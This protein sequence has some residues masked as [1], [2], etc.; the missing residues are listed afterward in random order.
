MKAAIWATVALAV[1]GAVMSAHGDEPPVA[2]DALPRI[3]S[4]EPDKAP[5]TMRLHDGLKLELVAS[6]P[7]VSSPVGMCFDEDG[8]LFVVEM[9]GYPDLREERPGRIK[10]LESTHHDGRYDKA[11]IYADNL[12]WPTS[13]LAYDG[14][15]FV[16][17]SPDLIYLKDTKHDGVADVRY[18]VF[19]GFGVTTVPLNVQGLVNGL[20]WGPDDRIW[21]TTSENGGSV[22]RPDSKD[23][24]LDLRR[25]DFSFDPRKLDLR[26]ENG[27]G[28]HGLSFDNFGR[29]YVCFNNKALQTF[30]YDAEYSGQNP[31]F[32]MPPALVDIFADGMDVYRI[33]PEEAWRVLRTQWRVAGAVSGPVEGGGRASGYFTS[34]SGVTIY[35]GDALPAQ[36][37]GNAFIAEPANN[38][39]HREVISPDGV[40]VIGHRAPEERHSEFLASTD[41]WFRP[42]QLANGPD[43]ALYV[44]DMYRET[45]EHPWSLPDSIKGRLDLHSGTERGRIWR[46]VPQGF[47]P[48]AMP[49]LSKA[50][51][52]ELVKLL[53]SLNGWHRDTAARLLYE[54]N[55]AS[56]IPLLK[57]LVRLPPSPAARYCALRSL[58]TLTENR[59]MDARILVEAMS[60]PEP[61]VR[62]LAV[63]LSEPLLRYDGIDGDL[64]QRLQGMANDP[65]IGVRYQLAFTIARLLNPSDA[66]GTLTK[67]AEHDPGDKWIQAAV[68]SSSAKQEIYLLLRLVARQD[69]RDS[70]AGKQFLFELAMLVGMRG[71]KRDLDL[72]IAQFGQQS[73]LSDAFTF[74]LARAF[75]E[76][77]AR[78][79]ARSQT[80][81]MLKDIVSRAMQQAADPA[82][83]TPTRVEAVRLLGTST[84]TEA[85]PVLL[86]LL[87]AIQPQAI[88]SAAISSLDRFADPQ[89]GQELVKRF[90]SFSPRLRSEALGV[91]AKRPDRA[92]EL[93]HAIESKTI[94]ASELPSPTATALRRSADPH[95][96][97]L[98]ARVL[99][100][101]AAGSRDAVVAAYMPALQLAGNADRGRTIYQQRC[102]SC[103]RLEGQG[104][105]VG[106]DLV[107]V[108]SAGKEKT[109]TNILDPNREIAPNYIAYIAETTN[110]ES[111][112]GVIA[113]ETGNSITLRQ[114]FG[115][116][117]TILRS[118]LKRLVSQRISLMPE[119]LEEGLKPQDFADLLEF[120]MTAK[121]PAT[122][123]TR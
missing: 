51:T 36:F 66:V 96:R 73:W 16:T 27:G 115:K 77:L 74:S 122:S 42:V 108:R 69:V 2:R 88:Q 67:I 82:I 56:A 3:A 111:L 48:P 34:C 86:P 46:I 107:T 103:H 117:T 84:Y 9:L 40:G 28:Q 106:P 14:G 24:P 80:Q 30:M 97:E 89:V 79:P 102:I 32:A 18:K 72:L 15:I 13:V 76:G 8:R 39:V 98:A 100:A 59:R 75:R 47:T 71:E 92:M 44:I 38:L 22:K 58:F 99:S 70:A 6:E 118:D 35:S 23:P 119:G 20:T 91:L 41:T 62:A 61:R 85:S 49:T 81:E 112:V 114:A 64:L 21:G 116:D 113:S 101:P 123:P 10:L 63:K 94:R 4:T 19:T 12:P 68:I 25:R 29:R 54:R 105:A 93:L 57:E 31:L 43:G 5:L 45:I 26:A 110:G 65:D 37:Q 109:L 7:L 33:S 17:A 52:P 90:A 53:E 120:V 1:M 50:T 87:D 78:G 83:A 60:D 95:V 104:N 121:E 55:D 11:T